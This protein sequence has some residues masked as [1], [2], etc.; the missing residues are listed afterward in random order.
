MVLFYFL[1]GK[2]ICA[3]HSIREIL[4]RSLYYHQ[5]WMLRFS[6]LLRSVSIFTF[7][8]SSTRYHA[9]RGNCRSMQ[10]LSQSF[11]SFFVI[12]CIDK[13]SKWSSLIYEHES[14]SISIISYIHNE[15]RINSEAIISRNYIKFVNE[16]NAQSLQFLTLSWIYAI[17]KLFLPSKILQIMNHSLPTTIVIKRSK[18]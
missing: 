5:N 2:P 1:G 3:D 14:I 4:N 18:E 11:R 8:W 13:Q 6:V 15:F 12:P 7:I 9:R 17:S 10:L 16:K